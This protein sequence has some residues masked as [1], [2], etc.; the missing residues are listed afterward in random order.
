MSVLQ[1]EIIP[2]EPELDYASGGKDKIM[3][4]KNISPKNN[5][6]TIYSKQQRAVVYNSKRSEL[7]KNKYLKYQKL[8]IGF[9]KI[10][11]HLLAMVVWLTGDVITISMLNYN[12]QKNDV[13]DKDRLRLLIDRILKMPIDVFLYF[14]PAI[15]IEKV[16]D[17]RAKKMVKKIL[18][19]THPQHASFAK[20]FSVVMAWLCILPLNEILKPTISSKLVSKIIKDT[21]YL[22]D[23]LLWFLNIKRS[24]L[25]TNTSHDTTW[26][27]SKKSVN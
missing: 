3:Y 4:I 16:L 17:K 7:Q 20:S 5:R 1:A 2:F 18:P 22:P 9:S 27:L 6:H 23:W 26:E 13:D 14:L 24:E 21:N 19:E 11:Y 8:A 25:Q 12:Y 15:A 10:P